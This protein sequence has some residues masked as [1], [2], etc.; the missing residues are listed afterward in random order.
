MGVLAFSQMNFHRV[1]METSEA[2]KYSDSL[3]SSFHR[4]LQ[5]DDD[6]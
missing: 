1:S 3:H 4:S 2:K 6:F 5:D